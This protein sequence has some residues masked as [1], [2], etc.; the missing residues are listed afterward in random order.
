MTILAAQSAQGR[1]T[2]CEELPGGITIHYTDAASFQTERRSIFE[3]RIYD[4]TTDA[5]RPLLIDGGA[6]LGMAA[7]RWKSLMPNARILCFEPDESAFELLKKNIVA[8]NLADIEPIQAGLSD[9]EGVVAFSPD[10]SDGGRIL[11][12]AQKA[13]APRS[14]RTVKL[15]DFIAKPVEM[16]KLNIEGQEWPV[17]RELEQS[18]KLT[19]VRRIILEYHGWPGGRQSLGDILNLLDRAGFRYLL[20]D[21]D[22]ETNPTT[23]PPFRI[24]P[25]AP[26]FCLI[27]AERPAGATQIAA[28]S[29]DWGELRRTSPVS[30]VFGLDRGTPID[31]H[32][33]ENFL[34]RNASDI[35]GRVL[36]VAD[37]TYT[38]RFG[39]DRVTRSDVLHATPGS[40][41][42]TL[43]GDLAT[44]QG[45]P[46]DTFD[47]IILTQTLHCIEDARA[48]LAACRRALRPGGVLLATLP[49]ISQ[50][51]RYDMDRWGDY[52]RFTSLSARRLFAERFADAN[53]TIECHGNALA[54]TAFLQGVSAEE[55]TP[56]ELDECDRDYEL[57]L[58]L[59]AVKV[60]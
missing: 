40:R 59:R 7:I 45:I 9:R 42:A 25:H 12:D 47:C 54:A 8:N 32:Y 18:G 21:F 2:L 15:S 35:R 1:R 29:I 51:S 50:I 6:H 41:H 53:L 20:H 28:P 14:I 26:W 38:R 3:N 23:K 27:Y 10:G 37:A 33:I 30:R 22:R 49:G 39:A 17:L 58:T 31:R 60:P 13:A 19:Q 11:P 24:R 43:I 48:A 46:D 5:A 4:F 56:A 16:L 36:E 44:G 34:E 52:W 55:L 57:L